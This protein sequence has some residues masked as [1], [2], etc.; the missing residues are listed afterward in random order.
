MRPLEPLVV[1]F[2][3]PVMIGIASELW[4]RDAKNASLLATIGTILAVWLCLEVRDPDGTW[5]SLAAFL[6]LPLPVAFALAAALICHGRS[7]GRRQH[8]RHEQ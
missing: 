1:L 5:N 3:L 4:L 6:V 7:H 2:L 8:G